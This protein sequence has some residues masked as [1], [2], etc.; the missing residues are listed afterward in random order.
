MLNIK[1]DDEAL[2]AFNSQN[3]SKKTAYITYKIDAGKITVDKNV[4]K[5]DCDNDY[6]EQFIQAVKESGSLTYMIYDI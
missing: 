1:G 3:L 4:Q 5:I 2:A 6:L